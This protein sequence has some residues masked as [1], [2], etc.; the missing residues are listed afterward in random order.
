[1]MMRVSSAG[2]GR[3]ALIISALMNP[4]LYFQPAE[5]TDSITS[6]EYNACTADI[7]NST[8]VG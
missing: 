7:T 8:V 5:N 4:L 1:M 3:L 2:L 6:G